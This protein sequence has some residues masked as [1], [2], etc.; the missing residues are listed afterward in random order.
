MCR[1]EST[2]FPIGI[3]F[4]LR[5]SSIE[6]IRNQSKSITNNL[7]SFVVFDHL[8]VQSGLVCLSQTEFGERNFS[9]SSVIS[10]G[11]VT[12]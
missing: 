7:I 1:F 5:L 8:P 11:I 4:I 2:I 9:K 6:M 12:L 10:V 3:A